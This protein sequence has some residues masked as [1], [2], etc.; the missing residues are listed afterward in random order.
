M[1]LNVTRVKNTLPAKRASLLSREQ[2]ELVVDA[3]A[4]VG[5]YGRV[6]RASGYRGQILSF[7]PTAAAYRVLE[8]ATRGDPKWTAKQMA[9]GDLNGAGII[10]VASASVCSSLLAVT[11]AVLKAAAGSMPVSREAVTIAR[12]DS[13][14]EMGRPIAIYLKLDVQGSELQVL[15]GCGQAIA[16]V[17][18]IESEVSFVKLYEGQVLAGEMLTE[19]ARL[20]FDPIWVERGFTDPE[21]NH[22]LQ[23][24][25]L[26]L[27]RDRKISQ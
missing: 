26:F 18:A 16:R 23:A 19:L 14:E 5:N 4:D 17:I 20:G 12:L 15:R 10:N 27:R 24:D 3:G 11:P 22:M 25:V 7:E 21:S 6:L 13:I 2:I 8:H 1:G 9:L